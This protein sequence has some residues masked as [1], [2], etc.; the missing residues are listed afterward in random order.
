MAL[1]TSYMTGNYAKIPIYFETILKAQAPE[2][3]TVKFLKDLGFKSSTDT[4]FINVL[5]S[6]RFLDDSGV[7][8]ELYYQL[9]DQESSKKI[10]AKQIRESYADL[11][12]LN[13]NAQDMQ[14][15]ELKGKFKTITEGQKKDS[16]IN[17]MVSTFVALCGYADWEEL[18]DKIVTNNND[19]LDTVN[20]TISP[21]TPDIPQENDQGDKHTIDL[22]YDIHIHLPATR[23]QAVYDALFASLTKHLNLK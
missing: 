8:T 13:M 2:K 10:I 11:F 1:P 4:Q 9:Y 21:N 19:N 18:D 16:T 5:K 3:F 12:A 6:L 22:N 7:P 15:D 14:R 17:Q 20:D 23:D